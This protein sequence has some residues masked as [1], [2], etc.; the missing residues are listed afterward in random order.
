MRSGHA[1]AALVVILMRRKTKRTLVSLA[2]GL[3]VPILAFEAG[4]FVRGFAGLR[5]LSDILFWVA[6]WPLALLKPITPDSED[7]SA[8]ARNL[9]FMILLAAPVL[10]IFGYAALTYVLLWWWRDNDSK[11]EAVRGDSSKVK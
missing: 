3:L 11:R 5:W 9:R 1:W 2:G 10:D 8:A 4:S 7:P 6:G